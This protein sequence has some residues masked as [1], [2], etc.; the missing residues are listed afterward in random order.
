[1]ATDSKKCAECGEVIKGRVDKKF[2]SDQCRNA[3]N[4]KLNSDSNNFVRNVNNALRRNRRILS[5]FLG[6]NEKITMAKQRLADEGF[7]FSYI[8]NNL[9]TRNHHTYHYCYEFGYMLIDNGMVLIV[10]KRND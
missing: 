10:K 1:M 5:T 2:C 4:N 9:V 7:N 6:K 3:H 8:T